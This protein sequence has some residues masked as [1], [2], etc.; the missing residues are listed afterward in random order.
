MMMVYDFVVIYLSYFAALW[1]RFD[2]RTSAIPKVLWDRAGAFLPFYCIVCVAVFWG[3]KLYKSIWRFASYSELIRMVAATA[4]TLVVHVI[5]IRVIGKVKA[6]VFSRMPTSYYILG[7]V[8]QFAFTVA[9]RFAYRFVTLV[10]SKAVSAPQKNVLLYGAGAAGQS[11]L[12]DANHTKE[13]DDRVVCIIDDDSN[14][15]HRTIDGVPI[16]GGRDELPSA[17]ERYKIDKIYIAIPTASAEQKRDIF[18]LCNETQCEIKQLPGM[19]QLIKGDVTVS[20]MKKVSVEDLLGRDPIRADLKEVFD[21]INGK[22]V[23]VTGGGGSIGS[24]LCRQIAGH[25]PKQ[26]IIFDVYDNNVRWMGMLSNFNILQRGFR[27]IYC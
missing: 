22:V 23:L 10:R 13:T 4:I 24:E 16:V 7:I 25:N 8:G 12:R 11:I 17:V 15:W 18:N 26:L 3:L 20:Q 5:G 21:Y 27:P 14:K 1:V 19:Y 9:I 6:P 2:M